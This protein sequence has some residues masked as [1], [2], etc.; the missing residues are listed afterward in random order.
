MQCHKSPGDDSLTKEF[1]VHFWNEIAPI[2]MRCIAGIKE[3]EN[4]CHSQK[5]G[6]ITLAYKK[7]GREFLK[8]YRP[9]SLQ[10]IDLKMITRTLA[11]RLSA[12]INKLINQS[13]KCLPGR[14]ILTNV[15]ILQNLID[16]INK[17]DYQA[18]VLFFDNEKAY[19]RISHRF[20]IKTLRHFGFGDDFIN[21]IQ[22]I[23]KDSFSSVKVIGFSTKYFPIERGL[24][25]GCPL[26]SLLY[27]LCAE[28]LGLEI[29]SNRKIV[30]VKYNNKEHKELR[31]A[32]DLSI[33]ITEM[34]SIDAIFE[35]LG[36]FGKATNSKINVDKTEALWLGRWK[37]NTVKPRNL[38]WTNKMVK[39]LG[40]YFG[41]DRVE[42]E[43]RGFE[44]IK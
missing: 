40:V 18:L 9:I 13:K 6:L 15:H 24:R 8:N 32:D 33:A 7:N 37:N 43:K 22:I 19:D 14:K 34:E 27:V 3:M 44:E 35:T 1:Y 41:N 23:Y 5:R 29:R 17:N 12:V 20:L 28:V 39:T 26:S 16:Y 30:G 36:K 4:L 25:Q 31:Y 2:Y 11:K 21:W 42:A 10:N 38:K